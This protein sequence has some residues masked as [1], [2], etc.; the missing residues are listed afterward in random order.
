MNALVRCFVWYDRD[1]HILFFNV[2]LSY[3]STLCFLYYCSHIVYPPCFLTLSHTSPSSS[4]PVFSHQQMLDVVVL[5]AEIKIN[6]GNRVC[7]AEKWLRSVWKTRSDRLSCSLSVFCVPLATAPLS[8]N[9]ISRLNW[10]RYP[11]SLLIR[12]LIHCVHVHWQRGR[13]RWEDQGW[14]RSTEMQCSLINHSL[15]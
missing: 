3:T 10:K 9:S 14:G 8:P 1:F 4:I 11:H 15:L 13:E 12:A 2:P 7:A 5:S 6:A